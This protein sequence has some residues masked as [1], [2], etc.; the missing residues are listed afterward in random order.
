MLI[1]VKSKIYLLKESV[2]DHLTTLVQEK[3]EKHGET[4]NMLKQDYK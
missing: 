1:Y 2:T 4:F 3:L